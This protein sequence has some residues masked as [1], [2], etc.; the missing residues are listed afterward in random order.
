MIGSIFLVGPSLIIRGRSVPVG[1]NKPVAVLL[2]CPTQSLLNFSW[3]NVARPQEVNNQPQQLK[4]W[5]L[6]HH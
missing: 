1:S 2:W 6:H 4:T 3:F 5:N